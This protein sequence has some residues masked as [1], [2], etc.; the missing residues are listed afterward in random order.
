LIILCESS[1]C[2]IL[3]YT[4]LSALLFESLDLDVSIFISRMSFD[5]YDREDNFEV[6]ES[7]K[8]NGHSSVDVSQ[9]SYYRFHFIPQTVVLAVGES[10]VQWE[11]L[12]GKVEC[13]DLVFPRSR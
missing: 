12:G 4:T 1:G 10:V 9:I 8:T 7:K 11:L 13:F 5:G 2:S 6:D 3:D